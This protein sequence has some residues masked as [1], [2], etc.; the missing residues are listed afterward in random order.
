M[1]L[2]HVAG[3]KR[4][5][6]NQSLCKDVEGTQAESPRLH[7]FSTPFRLESWK[8]TNRFFDLL[9]DAFDPMIGRSMPVLVLLD[10]DRICATEEAEL[11]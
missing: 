10:L 4:S 2:Y 3:L 11:P 9:L 1:G 7:E 6:A 8:R 5:K